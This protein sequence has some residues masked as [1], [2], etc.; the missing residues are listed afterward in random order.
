MSTA[1]ANCN[2]K[3]IVQLSTANIKCN[4]QLQLQTYSATVNCNCKHRV[5]RSPETANLECNGQ[6]QLQTYSATVS[7]HIVQ[8]STATV[9][10]KHKAQTFW[11]ACHAI[12]CGIRAYD[13]TMFSRLLLTL[14]ITCDFVADLIS[15]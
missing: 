1:S 10:R 13:H 9:K 2:C 12:N 15:L 11:Q 4:R 7:K 6:L 5:Q 3:H 8:P 14:M